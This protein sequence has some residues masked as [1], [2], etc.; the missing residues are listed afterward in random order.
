MLKE[1]ELIK[2]TIIFFLFAFFFS[3]LFCRI[4]IFF[5]NDH[6]INVLFYSL[7]VPFALLLVRGKNFLQFENVRV[8]KKWL[9][10][11]FITPFV[12][13]GTLYLLGKLFF[14][15]SPDPLNQN[16]NILYSIIFVLFSVTFE[17]VGWRGY[18]YKYFT[19]EGWFKMNLSI[20]VFW[21][22][23]HFPAIIYGGYTIPDPFALG[24]IL[25]F[26]N[27]TLG[28]F[29]LGWMRQ[30]TGGIFSPILIHAGNNIAMIVF[31]VSGPLLSESG[32]IFTIFLTALVVF[33][34]AWKTPTMFHFNVIK[35]KYL[36]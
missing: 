12:Y 36:G 25:F 30:K 19:A 10:I 28:S 17:E 27:L 20:S 8:Q 11:A 21:T 3:M 15:F 33:A 22:L 16:S 32:I 18:L 1:S 24:I 26:I 5:T 9:A 31:G 13:T 4:S 2:K 35:E 29:I 6:R 23:W 7:G 34:K 14:P